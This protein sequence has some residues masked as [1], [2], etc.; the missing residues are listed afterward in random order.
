[1]LISYIIILTHT[2]KEDVDRDIKLP[3]TCPFNMPNPY[4]TVNHHPRMLTFYSPPLCPRP[5]PMYPHPPS[6]DF[7]SYSHPTSLLTPMPLTPPVHSF[8]LTYF[9]TFFAV[10]HIHS[11]S[12]P[13]SLLTAMPLTPH[14]L[15]PVNIFWHT[16]CSEGGTAAEAFPTSLTPTVFFLFLLPP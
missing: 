7:H 10:T 13:T 16:F 11:D 4:S 6:I 5:H 1:M 14:V 3:I 9:G 15:L 2:I 12:H 8:Q